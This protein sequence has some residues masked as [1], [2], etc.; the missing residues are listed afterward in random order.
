MQ[1][2][3]IDVHQ[4]DDIR[5]YT[6]IEL[7]D[8][9][10]RLIEEPLLV[11]MMKW[12]YPGLSKAEII[13]MFKS[14]STV[15]EFQ[16]EIGAPAMKV[17]TQMT[18]SGL[19]FSNVDY[20]DKNKGYLF[21]SNHRDI[22]LD[23]ALLNVSLMERGFNT[24]EI[25]IG[26]NLLKAPMVRDIVRSNRNFIVNRDVNTK[27]VYYYSLRLS[28]YI[29][30]TISE[31]NTSIWIAQREGR[32]K[33]GDDKTSTGLLKMF[34]M[35]SS[36][37]LEDALDDLNIVPMSVSYEYDPCD[38]LKTHEL[39][40]VRYFGKYEKKSGEDFHSMLTGI[41]GHKGRVHIAV[42]HELSNTLDQMRLITNKNEKI[43]MLGE[44]IDEEMY[45]I[46]KLW[47]TNYIAYD[48][49]HGTREYR[50]HYSNIQRIA[51]ANYIRGHVIKLALGRKKTGL[52]SENL[53]A[54]AREIL[55][56]MYANPVTN[57]MVVEKKEM[58][59]EK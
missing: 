23:S 20:I 10:G 19:S 52:P 42:G 47:P 13:R 28:N 33:D 40:H 56:Q 43:R 34:A 46:Y 48:M 50:D 5:P 26:D 32:S 18:T 54:N 3:P 55:L 49:L 30:H 51:F 59:Q 1:D 24:T 57:R 4:Y 36:K 16:E 35:S 9:I 12:V 58:L 45:R 37:P 39:L 7:R 44:A 6:D 21:I 11:K 2:A 29:R 53:N 31:R 8:A 41:T 38:I 25:A 15:R 27:E 14:I 22:I 17:I